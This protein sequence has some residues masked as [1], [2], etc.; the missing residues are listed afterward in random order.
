VVW[1]NVPEQHFIDGARRVGLLL[2]VQQLLFPAKV[3]SV[4]V[5]G[6]SVDEVNARGQKSDAHRVRESSVQ[7]WIR[8]LAVILKRTTFA[9]VYSKILQHF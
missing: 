1:Q 6:L 7:P 5:V 8:S 2:L 4:H 9:R 3:Q